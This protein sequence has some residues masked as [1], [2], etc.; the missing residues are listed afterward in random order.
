MKDLR[1]SH[2]DNDGDKLEV[3]AGTFGAVLATGTADDETEVAVRYQYL[4]AL[5]SALQGIL[6]ESDHGAVL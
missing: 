2:T 5:I 3:R 4:P 6:N 1:F